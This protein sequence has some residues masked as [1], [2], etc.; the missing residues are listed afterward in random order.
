M[1]G[2]WPPI[3]VIFDAGDFETAWGIGARF[4]GANFTALRI[5]V[6]RGR[7]GL[8]LI[9][10]GSQAILMEHRLND[11]ALRPRDHSS[12]L[13]RSPRQRRR[14][15]SARRR[16]ASIPDDPI[17]REPMT[18]DV[19]SAA[20]YEPDLAYQTLENLFSTPGDPVLGQRAKNINTV[21]EVPDGPYFVNR[22]G[23]MPLTPALVARGR[24]HQ[25]RPGARQV[26]G[27]VGEERRRHAGLH[28][29]RLRESAVVRQVRS[30]GLARH[31][32]RQRDRRRETVLGGRLSHRRIPHR[33]AGAG[34]TW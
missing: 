23:R 5:E 27:G 16:G 4:H 19:K 1:P 21:D 25:Q 13:T 12:R 20:R 28:D 18:Q 6:A 8:R 9:F 30:A 33:A 15:R 10:A 14:R 26:D 32:H 7:E 3:A 31:G 34:A 11:R 22:A 29:S 24:Q 2:R 17:W